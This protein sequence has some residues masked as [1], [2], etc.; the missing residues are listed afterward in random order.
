MGG[1]ATTSSPRER[2]GAALRAAR[3]SAGLSQHDVN[4]ENKNHVHEA[5]KGIRAMPPGT[6][7]RLVERLDPDTK[8]R[9]VYAWIESERQLPIVL[10]SKTEEGNVVTPN[11]LA[12]QVAVSFAAWWPTLSRAESRLALATLSVIRWA[13]SRLGSPPG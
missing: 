1:D 7:Q 3:A 4:P 2:F 13:L 11:A 8:H 10:Y 12:L 6:L 5:E 9:L